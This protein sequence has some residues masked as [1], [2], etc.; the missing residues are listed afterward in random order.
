MSLCPVYHLA[1]HLMRDKESKGALFTLHKEKRVSNAYT[2][3]QHVEFE[4]RIT[5]G[6]I[7]LCNAVICITLL[8]AMD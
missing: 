2:V 3:K 1:E 6:L 7:K 4:Q 5:Q 8:V